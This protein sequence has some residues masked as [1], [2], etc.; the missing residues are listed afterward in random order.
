MI[1]ARGDLDVHLLGV[2]R[3]SMLLPVIALPSY[4]IA[5]VLATV[6]GSMSIVSFIALLVPDSLHVLLTVLHR[7]S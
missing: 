4:T 1:A 3:P 2:G 5:A 6:S 7:R